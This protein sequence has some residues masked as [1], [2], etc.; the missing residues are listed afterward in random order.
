[1]QLRAQNI[2]FRYGK[3]PW[4]FKNVNFTVNSGEIVG[5]VGP[6]GYGK[7]TFC[8]ILAGYEAPSE[9][10]V[11]LNGFPIS[12]KGYHPVQLVFQHPEKAINPRWKMGKV[13]NEGWQ[14]NQQLLDALGIEQEWLTRF[15]NELS[16]GELQ[17]FCVARAL[18]P[19]TRYLIADEMT[20]MLDAITQ[21][22]IWNAVLKIAEQREMGMVV[23]SHDMNLIQ[24]LCHRVIEIDHLNT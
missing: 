21:A 23:V 24:Q 19:N 9:G 2:A 10:N 1:M 6:S 7:T 20:T 14:P 16:G 18:G 11:T 15:P 5:L 13:L 12:K 22:Q 4:L 17:R 8:R 3:E